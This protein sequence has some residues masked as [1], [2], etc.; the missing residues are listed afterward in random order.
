MSVGKPKGGPKQKPI[1]FYLFRG[2]IKL[3]MIVNFFGLEMVDTV[4]DLYNTILCKW[5]V[6]GGIYL[7]V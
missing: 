5:I 3:Q 2:P 1:P 6:N 7:M 4:H